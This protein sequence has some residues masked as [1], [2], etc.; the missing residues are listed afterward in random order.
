MSSVIN[1]NLSQ[2]LRGGIPSTYTLVRSYVGIRFQGDYLGLQDGLIEGRPLWPMVFY[3]LRSGDLS[4][5]LHCVKQSSCGDCQELVSLLEAKFKNPEHTDILKLETNIRFQYRRFVR[6]STDPFKRIVWSVLGC[7]DVIDEHTEV[8]KT[9]DDYLW[10]K[11]SLVRVD[12]DKD[13]HIKY[14]DL[15]VR[16]YV[17]RVEFSVKR[18]R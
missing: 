11:L 12:Y 8:A 15:Q 16:I 13:E 1:E 7:C 2:A 6:N 4:A 3:C 18:E 5:A 9:A 10:L 17:E 14:E